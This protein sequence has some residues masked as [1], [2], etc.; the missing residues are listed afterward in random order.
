ML[1]KLLAG[2]LAVV[3]LFSFSP[4]YVNAYFPE[5][6]QQ[7]I[8]LNKLGLLLHTNG[9]FALGEEVTRAQGA[10][11]LVRLLGK[12]EEARNLNLSHPFTDVPD[13]ASMYV[14][15][16]Y[17]NGLT[18]GISKT[19]YGTAQNMTV[20]QYVTFI[21]RA[22]GFSDK[23]GDFTL[24]TS[25]QKA[26]EVNFLSPDEAEKLKNSTRFLRDDLALISY[27]ALL[28]S[29][30]GSELILSEKMVQD[31]IVTEDALKE[32]GLLVPEVN[33]GVD[34]NTNTELIFYYKGWLYFNTDF[35]KNSYF[36]K[37]RLNGTGGQLVLPKPANKVYGD[38]IFVKS[39]GKVER[40]NL[41]GE[42][43]NTY[44]ITTD[45]L[46]A[47]DN[48]LYYRALPY[49]DLKMRRIS[50]DGTTDEIVFDGPYNIFKQ[51]DDLCYLTGIAPTEESDALV[52]LNLKTLEYDYYFAPWYAYYPAYC[53]YN[54][55]LYLVKASPP[56]YSKGPPSDYLYQST[57]CRTRIGELSL[58]ELFVIPNEL[59]EISS[60]EIY[61]DKIYYIKR[62]FGWPG[63]LMSCNIDGTNHKILSEIKLHGIDV[64]GDYF[65]DLILLIVFA[66]SVEVARQLFYIVDYV[67]NQF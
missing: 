35:F 61:N 24:P 60:L 50:F 43:L 58:E 18:S 54:G 27:N 65:I 21:L 41:N 19:K 44:N 56:S 7:A 13:W 34:I 6:L 16:C 12:E 4:H 25:L 49:S 59:H 39:S 33:A 42:L 36:M 67:F 38:N 30:K 62:I 8:A 9:D 14:G 46:F 52:C 45:L 5:N 23:D 55:Y 26:T 47:Y 66:Q 48:W 51:V 32:A 22:L 11:M 31:K 1:K 37:V 57:L 29:L 17:Q 20:E 28:A 53:E 15:Y 63:Y 3:L 64:I 2:F 10:I 40:Y